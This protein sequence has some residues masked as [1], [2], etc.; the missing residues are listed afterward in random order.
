MVT[1][2]KTKRTPTQK[3][4]AKLASDGL[5]IAS[6][7]PALQ[8]IERWIE[9]MKLDMDFK[10]I[11]ITPVIQTQGK[12]VRTGSFT[13]D[14]V[15]KDKDGNGSHE[16]HISSE[17]LDRPAIE[18]AATVRHELIHAKNFQDGIRDTSNN[19]IYHNKKFLESATAYGLVMD[20]FNDKNGH[21]ITKGFTPVYDAVIRQE[22]APDDDAF[23]L[24]RVLNETKRKTKAPVK[25][26]KWACP[27]GTIVR[28]AVKLTAVCTKCTKPFVKV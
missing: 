6:L 24:V 26:L 11:R 2:T 17:Y 9:Y 27:C 8:E 3:H 5:E 15:Y 23:K 12:R 21:G 25:M 28:C 10:P 16:I 4:V 18:I 14:L 19:G 13:P 7:R 22:L 1:T 20:E